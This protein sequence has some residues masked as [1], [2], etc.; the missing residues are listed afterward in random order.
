MNRIQSYGSHPFVRHG[1]TLAVLAFSTVYLWTTVDIFIAIE[2]VKSANLKIWVLSLIV[3]YATILFRTIRWR[4]LLSGMGLEPELRSANRLM[5]LSLFFNTILPAKSGDLYRCYSASE[6]YGESKSA[7]IGTVAVERTTD[8]TLLLLGLLIGSASLF[9]RLILS[10]LSGTAALGVSIVGMSVTAFYVIL[11]YHELVP[12]KV[13][14]ISVEFLRGF[15]ATTTFSGTLVFLLLS[16][17]IWS[18]NVVRIGLVTMSVGINMSLLNI[19]LI[20][21]LITVLTGL[22]ITPAGIGIVE[23]ITTSTLVFFGIAA[24]DGLAFVLVD[25]MI[26]IVSMVVFGSVYFYYT[27]SNRNLPSRDLEKP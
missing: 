25:R 4:F 8:I 14:D 3:F 2:Q 19:F 16:I 12:Q 24:S 22:P 9:E 7:H 11:S 17:V 23:A 27:Q 15:T 26:T 1:V 18:M 10:R 21:I 6:E 5:F 20:A 13:R